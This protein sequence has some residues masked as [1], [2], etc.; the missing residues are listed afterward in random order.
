MSLIRVNDL[1][2]V[3]GDGRRA[4]SDLDL[5][6][7]A[8]QVVGLLGR[9][10]AG[11]TTLLH[12]LLGLLEPAAGSVRLFDLDP[13]EEPLAVKRRIGQ[14]SEHDVLPPGRRVGEL[15]AFHRD[16]FPDWD[17]ALADELVGRFGLETGARIKTLSKGQARQVSLVC[18]VAHRPELLLLDEPAGGLDPAARREVLQTAIAL[19]AEAGTTVLFSSHHMPDVER[20]ASRVVLIHEGRLL[21]DDEVDALRE[22]CALAVLPADV[23]PRLDGLPRCLRVRDNGGALHVALAAPPAEAADLLGRHLDQA[24]PRTSPLNLEDLF[25]ELVG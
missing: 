7:P 3:Y 10:G 22:G 1:S 23:G 2:F 5:E 4:L 11:K 24:P 19:L 6:V 9:N 21:L 17:D 16:L 20:L 15:L 25:V 8:G 14:V 12:C 18:A 13:R